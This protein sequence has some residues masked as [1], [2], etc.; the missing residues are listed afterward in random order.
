MGFSSL[1]EH[2]NLWPFVKLKPAKLLSRHHA[3][4]D[5]QAS[6]SVGKQRPPFLF[7]SSVF[8]TGWLL[9]ICLKAALSCTLALPHFGKVPKLRRFNLPKLGFISCKSKKQTN[10]Y[11]LIRC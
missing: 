7:I 8:D 3:G 11:V 2:R 10:K 9:K 5:E 4:G 1:S 6:L